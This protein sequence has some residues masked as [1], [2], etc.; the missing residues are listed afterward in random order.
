MKR[1]KVLMVAV[2]ILVLTGF[3]REQTYPNTA[4]KVDEL[5]GKFIEYYVKKDGANAIDCLMRAIELDPTKTV[6]IEVPKFIING[7]YAEAIDLLE[8]RKDRSTGENE[9][10]L[11][12]ILA[13]QTH[14]LWAEELRKKNEYLDAI[15]HYEAA[16]VIDIIYRPGDGALELNNIG[17]SYNAFSQKQ[18]ALEY[19]EKAL[20]IF[21]EVGDRSGEA[22]VLNNIGGIYDD[23][24]QKQKA[25]GY[26][27]KALPILREVRNRSVEASTLNN[28]GM[29]YSS[30]GQKQKGLEY[31]EEALR[32][33]R[34]VGDQSGEAAMMDNIG[35]VYSDL[36]Q[37]QKALEYYEKALPIFHE[38]GN[39]YG[40]AM[41]LNS[42]GSV[43][44]DLGQK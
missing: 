22:T 23:L 44:Y 9:L 42:I 28:I 32:I 26:Y 2:L 43:Y 37:M 13:A 7:K 30:L 3:S 21:R 34:E 12:Q 33:S 36:G 31:Y 41:T 14:F 24:G 11:I 40:E 16:Y 1:A 35:K 38:V 27:E 19:Y 10:K 29:V 39:R 4:E 15:V 17:F 25:L 6:Y 18:K 20:S 5:L 8:Q